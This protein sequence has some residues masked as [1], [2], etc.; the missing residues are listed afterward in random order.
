M[1]NL[2]L[3]MRRL[4]AERPEH[5]LR[6]W[7]ANGDQPMTQVWGRA[8]QPAGEV[9][10]SRALTTS[11]S[12]M[13]LRVEVAAW[14]REAASAWRLV[15]RAL[16]LG[17]AAGLLGALAFALES[18]RSGLR[19]LGKESLKNQVFLQTATDGIHIVDDQG[20]LLRFSESFARML[21]YTGK[22]SAG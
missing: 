6:A 9:R 17:L 15:A 19:A 3:L 10:T 16:G 18:W 2:S 21:G 7:I 4:T 5:E 11:T 13:G 20:N 22:R 8:E 14:P 1:V 12:G